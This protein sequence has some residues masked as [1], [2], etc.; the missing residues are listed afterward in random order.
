MF[1]LRKDVAAHLKLPDEDVVVNPI[2]LHIV[3]KVC[4][5][6]MNGAYSQYGQAGCREM[7]I[8]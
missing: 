1:A 7:E 6:T 8:G 5:V 3:V 4:H 2:T